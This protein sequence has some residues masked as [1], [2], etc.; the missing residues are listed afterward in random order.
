MTKGERFK[1]FEAMLLNNFKFVGLGSGYL[2]AEYFFIGINPSQNMEHHGQR[3]LG[4]PSNKIES[5]YYFVPL[6]EKYFPKNY[7]NTNLVKIPTY[8]NLLPLKSEVERFM[9]FLKQ[10]LNIIQPKKI[11]ALGN[12]VHETLLKYNIESIKIYHPAY[13]IRTG[14]QQIH[15]EQIRK[16]YQFA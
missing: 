11:I 16:I 7:Y 9:P 2:N 13:I 12:W 14:K 15:E 10:E 5:S 4:K 3:C 1:L 6:V 8:H